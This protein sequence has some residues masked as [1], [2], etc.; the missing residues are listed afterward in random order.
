MKKVYSPL[1]ESSDIS[2]F[3]QNQ[4]PVSEMID[5]Y[6]EN[7]ENL[8]GFVPSSLEVDEEEWTK[9]WNTFLKNVSF[10]GGISSESGDQQVVETKGK[11]FVLLTQYEMNGYPFIAM[12]VASNKNYLSCFT[13]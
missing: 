12:F 6:N 1:F 8:E 11:P 4:I 7:N 9:N 5:Y 13:D 2:F 3:K 10:V